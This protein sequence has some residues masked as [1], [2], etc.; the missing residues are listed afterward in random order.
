MRA[1]QPAFRRVRFREAFGPAH[2]PDLS[3]WRLVGPSG[4]IADVLH[5]AD[6]PAQRLRGLLGRPVLP[7]GHAFILRP[8]AQVHTFGMRYAIDAVFC[9][10]ELNVLD[11]QTLRPGRISRHVRKA[12]CC[13]EL[14]AGRAAAAG[15][16]P[17]SRLELQRT[18]R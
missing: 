14:S 13:I 9:D 2:G 16:G 3:G 5:P 15:L 11:V 4:V 17:G 10:R 12:W 18:D 8:C 6:T 7:D 1:R